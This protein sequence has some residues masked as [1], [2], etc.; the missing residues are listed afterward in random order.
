MYCK[1]GNETCSLVFKILAIA[2]LAIKMN[3]QPQKETS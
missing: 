2:W 3:K 1:S